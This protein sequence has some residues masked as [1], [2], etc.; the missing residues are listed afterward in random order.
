MNLGL[1]LQQVRQWIVKPT[2]EYL[3][4]WSLSAERLVLGTAVH[5]T[6]AR[7]VTQNEATARILERSK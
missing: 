1:D 4:L 5:Q 7:V 2:L 6:M 3:G